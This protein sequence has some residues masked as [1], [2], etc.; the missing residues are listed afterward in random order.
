MKRPL[1]IKRRFRR[2]GKMSIRCW[3]HVSRG[4][5][6][7]GVPRQRRSIHREPRATRKDSIAPSNQA[8]KAPVSSVCSFPI[9]YALV[10]LQTEHALDFASRI[11]HAPLTSILSPQAGRGGMVPRIAYIP[12][13]NSCCFVPAK[14]EEHIGN[15]HKLSQ[16]ERLLDFASPFSK[17]RG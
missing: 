10:T 5:F 9:P 17:G 13:K 11:E 7:T 1:Y 6:F 3:Q 8:L 12:S 14:P 2:A 15:S 4:N 16:I